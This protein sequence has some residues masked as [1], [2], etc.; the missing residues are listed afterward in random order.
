MA[1]V[2]ITGWGKD[3]GPAYNVVSSRLDRKKNRRVRSVDVV[4]KHSGRSYR[5]PDWRVVSHGDESWLLLNG[6]HQYTVKMSVLGSE[7]VGG[8]DAADGSKAIAVADDT[9]VLAVSSNSQ[10]DS[11]E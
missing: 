4:R 5:G 1:N 2:V 7:I 10:D 6:G 9:E 3:A 8:I 11:T